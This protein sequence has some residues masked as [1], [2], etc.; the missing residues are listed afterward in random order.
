MAQRNALVTIGP[1]RLRTES[2]WP[3]TPAVR[4][5]SD[6]S[7]PVVLNVYVEDVDDTVDRAVAAGARIVMALSGPSRRDRTVWIMDLSGL[8]WKVGT[9]I[10]ETTDE[11]ERPH[12]SLIHTMSKAGPHRPSRISSRERRRNGSSG[13][14]ARGSADP[15][16]KSAG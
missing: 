5:G 13:P 9:R 6:D 11:Q 4:R 2:E 8:V 3:E 10:D 7:P 1:A 12:L 14:I 16:A 15:T